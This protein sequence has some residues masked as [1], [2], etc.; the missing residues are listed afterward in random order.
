MGEPSVLEAH[1][2]LDAVQDLLDLLQ[3]HSDLT[4]KSALVRLGTVEDLFIYGHIESNKFNVR[5]YPR[6]NLSLIELHTC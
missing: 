2:Y 1:F 3:V 5:G 6:V 4:E